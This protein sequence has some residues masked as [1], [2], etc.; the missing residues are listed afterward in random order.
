MFRGIE[1]QYQF[2]SF[3]FEYLASSNIARKKNRKKHLD[4]QLYRYGAKI[5]KKV[6]VVI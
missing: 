4:G 1:V 6:R 2:C 5:I 3:K